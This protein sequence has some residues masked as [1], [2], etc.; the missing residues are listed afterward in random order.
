MLRDY[1][2]LD[3]NKWTKCPECQDTSKQFTAYFRCGFCGYIDKKDIAYQADKLEKSYQDTITKMVKHLIPS[4]TPDI[5]FS[6]NAN[7]PGRSY[8]C[9][10]WAD[11]NTNTITI[12]KKLLYLP[13]DEIVDTTSHET[14]H[15]PTW[16]EEPPPGWDPDHGPEWLETYHNYRADLFSFKSA[17][18]NASNPNVRFTKGYKIQNRE[19]YYDAEYGIK[20]ELIY[21][22]NE[23]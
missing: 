2:D 11:G 8:I 5:V 16:N 13:H 1:Y 9:A 3:P 14:A 10:G 19:N 23:D 21:D 6:E 15:I 17:F 7:P 4:G 22:P 20:K 12:P 18:V